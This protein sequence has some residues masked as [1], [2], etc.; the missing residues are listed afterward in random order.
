MLKQ[1]KKL[2]KKKK[3]F[4]DITKHLK[5]PHS[6]KRQRLVSLHLWCTQDMQ[7]EFIP[8]QNKGIRQTGLLLL[9]LHLPKKH[10]L[11]LNSLVSTISLPSVKNIPFYSYLQMGSPWCFYFFAAVTQIKDSTLTSKLQQEEVAS[12]SIFPEVS[13]GRAQRK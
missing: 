7:W 12:F 11:L 6:M 2:K 10:T 13:I 5:E 8:H 1:K 3:G 4:S 9:L